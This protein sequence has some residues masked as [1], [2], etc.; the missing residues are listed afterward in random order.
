LNYRNGKFNLFTSLNYGTNIKR[1]GLDISRNFL[2]QNT[3][4]ILS[5][6]DQKAIMKRNGKSFSAKA[7][8]DYYASKK[9]TLGFVLSGFSN[10]RLND[11]KTYTD[12]F[13]PQNVL[14]KKTAALSNNDSKWKN[15]SANGYFKT[16][17]DSIGQEISADFDY[18]QY[19]S[20]NIQPLISFY[21]DNNGQLTKAPDTLNGNLPQ[22]IT[23]YSA[24]TDYTKPFKKWCETGSRV[25]IQFCKNR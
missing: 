6:F 2:D 17:L 7:G 13:D 9:T 19:S 20:T 24:K 12:I 4:T 22:D 25:K 15:F 8:L 5:V 11:N 3:K 10:S 23:I 14:L 18:I 21:Y 16:V 1:E